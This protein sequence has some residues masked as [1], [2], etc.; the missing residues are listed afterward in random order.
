M[1]WLAAITLLAA[2]YPVAGQGIFEGEPINYGQTPANDRVAQ[3]AAALD[4]GEI[5]LDFD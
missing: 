4:A 5:E 1:S 3:L 2:A